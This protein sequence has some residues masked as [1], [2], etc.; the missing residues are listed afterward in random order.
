M[1]KGIPVFFDVNAARARLDL[2]S[3]GD[4]WIDAFSR[5]LLEKARYDNLESIGANI[6]ILCFN[7]DRCIEYYLIEAIRQT[8]VELSYEDAHR[9]VSRIQFIHP[10]GTLGAL[11]EKLL[12]DGNNSIPF[13]FD[14]K[15]GFDPWSVLDKL[16]TYTEQIEDQDMLTL[17]R[18]AISEASQIVFLGFAFH[19]QNMALMELEEATSFKRIFSTGRG[20]HQREEPEIV[21][22]ILKLYA[23]K[24][25]DSR[26]RDNIYI[27]HGMSCK[28]LFAAHW[29]NLSGA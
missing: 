27:E 7:Y 13:G 10:Y 18:G 9:I 3:L 25:Q 28:E 23:G 19:P 8:F 29:R 20:I 26:W 22:R 17:I 11:P 24:T 1:L 12:G 15:H 21:E 5:I 14:V 2:P 4:T 6:S 16:K